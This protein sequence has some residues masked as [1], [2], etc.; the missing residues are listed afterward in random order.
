MG[1]FFRVILTTERHKKKEAKEDIDL[2]RTGEENP[3]RM[4]LKG[5]ARDFAKF[6]TKYNGQ[7]WIFFL[8]SCRV[9][10]STNP[11]HLYAF[12]LKK[13]YHGS[14]FLRAACYCSSFPGKF[15]RFHLYRSVYPGQKYIDVCPLKLVISI[16]AM[17]KIIFSIWRKILAY[18]WDKKN[19]FIYAYIL[20]SSFSTT[21][22]SLS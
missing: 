10:L 4:K 3:R 13:L 20:F 6:M 14:L 11:A 22:V 9:I 7:R 8:K 16:V 12:L 21:F 1:R 18:S 5:T 19:L 2:D 17:L 15:V